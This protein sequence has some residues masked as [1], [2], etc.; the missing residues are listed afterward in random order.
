MGA[1]GVDQLVLLHLRP[2]LYADRAG[3]IEEVV[4]G[5]LLVGGA[6]PALLQRVALRIGSGIGDP[7][8]LLLVHALAAQLFVALV[9]LDLLAVAL[10][11][12]PAPSDR[13]STR[14]NS[15]H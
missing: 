15:S 7:R 1:D 11:H 6:L 12:G 3:A 10:R 8:R 9:V 5:P 14:L 13:K 4:L 2:P